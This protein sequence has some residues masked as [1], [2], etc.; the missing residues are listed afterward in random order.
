V[1][2]PAGEL[3]DRFHLLRLPKLLLDDLSF[4]HVLEHEDDAAEPAFGAIEGRA[5]EDD[6]DEPTVLALPAN[7]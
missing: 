7:R 5:R 4:G 1:G 2:E 6:I 3:A